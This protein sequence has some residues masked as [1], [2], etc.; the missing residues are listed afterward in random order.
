MILRSFLRR[1]SKCYF[2]KI[3]DFSF[4]ESSGHMV[5]IVGILQTDIGRQKQ[6]KKMIIDIVGERNETVFA[7]QKDGC[8]EIPTV[9]MS[10][11]DWVSFFY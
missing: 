1:N 5:Y 3:H 6:I 2:V 10:L 9:I 8:L 7:T 11:I 4:W